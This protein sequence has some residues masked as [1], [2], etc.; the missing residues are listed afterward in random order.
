VDDWL[1]QARARLAAEV[2]DDAA[3]YDLGD[4]EVEKP[5]KLAHVAA[6]T[7]GDRTNAPLIA[8]L[9]GVASG[10]HPDRTAT[11]LVRAVTK[12]S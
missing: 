3:S 12:P 5:L 9:V 2:G 4:D 7:S 8:Y 11:E 10:R 6:H 1:R